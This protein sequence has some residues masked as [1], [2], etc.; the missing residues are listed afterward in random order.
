MYR[1]F[2]SAIS[3]LVL[4]AGLSPAVY[5]QSQPK[6]TN[7][8]TDNPKADNT[9]A[10]ERDRQKDVPTADQQ[11]EKSSDRK[12][13]QDVRHA[14]VADKS[15]STY[16]HNVKVIVQNGTV[17]LKGPVRSEDES[18]AVESKAVD[19]AG[20]GNVKNELSVKPE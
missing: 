19:V 5:A 8:T 1:T 12:L 16:A 2:I 9:K 6:S 3:A 4:A 18:H 17:T 11:K 20:T 15:L 13:A 7:P 10:N 14:I